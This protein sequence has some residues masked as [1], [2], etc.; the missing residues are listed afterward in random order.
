MLG[1]MQHQ[2]N[3][4]HN[5]TSQISMQPSEVCK[6]YRDKSSCKTLVSASYSNSVARLQ[7]LQKMVMSCMKVYL[8]LP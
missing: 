8:K 3:S 1:I 5:L 7:I 2:I 4:A 6:L